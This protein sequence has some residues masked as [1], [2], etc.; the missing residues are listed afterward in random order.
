MAFY[1]FICSVMY[2]L[3]IVNMSSAVKVLAVDRLQ[4]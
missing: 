2:I 1:L 4:R 3:L